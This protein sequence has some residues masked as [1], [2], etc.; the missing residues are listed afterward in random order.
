MERMLVVIF[1]G[2]SKAYEAADALQDLNETGGVGMKGEWVLT[3]QSDGTVAV[4]KTDNTLPEGSMG[5]AVI[6]SLIGLF[7]GPVGLAIGATSGL[8]VGATADI[9]RARLDQ[10]FVE[11]VR[12]SLAPGKAA[13]VAEIEEDEPEA[14]DQRMGALGGAVLRR[15][16]SDIAD[17]DYERRAGDVRA[18][19]GQAKQVV[20]QDRTQRKGRAKARMNALLHRQDGDKDDPQG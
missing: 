10:D 6:G 7:G 11:E 8:V 19:L 17:A 3:R 13:L 18:R 14:V 12:T 20:A 16:M 9:A 1:N 4:V 5:G 2:E 15:D